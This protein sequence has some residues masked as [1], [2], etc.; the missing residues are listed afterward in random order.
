M[1]V[2]KYD[3]NFK[4]EVIRRVK[5]KG[6]KVQDLSKELGINENTIYSWIGDFK[7]DK[8]NAFPGSGNL[9]PEDEEV[10]RLKRENADLKE[11]V[12]ILKKAAVYFAKHQK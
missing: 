11:E 2:K 4:I 7:R 8:E 3:R 12:E 6:H 9:K 10:R 1:S 5:E